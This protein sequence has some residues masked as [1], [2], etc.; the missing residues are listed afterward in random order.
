MHNMLFSYPSHHS[1]ENVCLVKL[2]AANK[3]EPPITGGSSINRVL[4]LVA[5][6]VVARVFVNRLIRLRKI[7]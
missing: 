3:K 2:Y 5:L 6:V 4:M 1:P 7:T